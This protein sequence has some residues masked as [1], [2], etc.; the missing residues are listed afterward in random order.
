VVTDDTELLLSTS[1]K[2][3][4]GETTMV[5]I[6]K[7]LI[8]SAVIEVFTTAEGENVTVAVPMMTTNLHSSS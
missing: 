1:F 6:T 3:V 2:L 8:A 7:S 5:D 4:V